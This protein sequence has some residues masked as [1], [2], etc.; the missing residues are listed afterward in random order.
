VLD[1]RRRIKDR[2]G[3]DKIGRERNYG[4]GRNDHDVHSYNNIV[5]MF[6]R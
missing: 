1:E 3:D 4:E 5:V 6:I 2:E